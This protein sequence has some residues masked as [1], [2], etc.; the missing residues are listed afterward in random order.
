[1]FKRVLIISSVLATTLAATF[2]PSNISQ[3]ARSQP[4]PAIRNI[5]AL[6]SATRSKVAAIQGQVR[7]LPE[8]P[9]K[10]AATVTPKVT[11]TPA[12]TVVPAPVD[13]G[14]GSIQDRIVAT[15]P[16]DDAKVLRVIKCESN[17]NPNARSKSGKYWGLF[18][19]DSNFR[20]AY[21]WNS[22]SVEDQVMMG[23]RGYQA[24]G[25]Q[26]WPVCGKR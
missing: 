23:W 16:G 19:A 2:L 22:G 10:V 21:G 25:W 7:G 9:K 1:M 18:Q 14:S 5:E 4:Q 6:Q 17:F 12:P 20:A 26:P 11:E 3:A 15:W 13:V 8:A 24:R